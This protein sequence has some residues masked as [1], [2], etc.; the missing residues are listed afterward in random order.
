MTILIL[1]T[2]FPQPFT[3]LGDNKTDEFGFIIISADVKEAM[4]RESVRARISQGRSIGRGY[5]CKNL[6]RLMKH[7][8][9]FTP[10][11]KKNGLF[12]CDECMIAIGCRRCRCCGRAG[13]KG[14]QKK[15]VRID[16]E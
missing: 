13:H 5:H 9:R 6:C 10:A 8:T 14:F 16:V 7:Y 4:Y 11:L 3:L 15:D 2:V 12:W 1:K